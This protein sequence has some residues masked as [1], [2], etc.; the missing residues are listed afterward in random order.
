MALFAD[1]SALLSTAP[2]NVEVA[3]PRLRECRD[4]GLFQVVPALG[5]DSVARCLRCNAVMR[6]TRRD[7]L[8]R[9]LALNIAALSLFGVACLMSLMTVSTAGMQ[10]SANLFSGPEGL[11]Q[12]GIWELSVIV[13]FTTVA[14]PFLRFASMVYVLAGLRMQRPP[15]HL[16]QVFSWMEH[17]R[18]WSMIEVY[19]LGV[20]VAYVK[21]VGMVHIEIG[22]A[23]YAL[24][25]LMLTTVAA[26]AV[27]DRQAVWDEME[28]RGIPRCRQSTMPRSRSPDPEPA[29]SRCDT[30]GL[31]SM[32][33]P[34]AASHCPR[35]GSHLHARK[36][37]S[38]Q[39]TWALLIASVILYVPANVYPVL[40]VVQLGSGAPS[41]ILG[42]VEEL[43]G[44]R[45]VAAGG[46]GFLRQHHGAGAQA[47]RP[48]DHAGDHAS[49]LG[50][51]TAR[52]HGAVPDRQR[53]R[54]LVDDRHLH[55]ID[56]GRPRPVRL[57]GHD[58]T[59]LR[60][61]GVRRGRDPD[62][63]RCRSIRPAAHVGRCRAIAGESRMT[64]VTQP[65]AAVRSR[66]DRRRRM[67]LIWVIPLVTVLI[68]AWLVWDTY[69]KRGPTITITFDG[70]EGLQAGQSHVKHKDL[71]MGLVKSLVLTKDLQHV[72]VT[73]QMNREAE[74]LLTDRA[75]F[76]VVKPRFSAGNISG[77]STLLSGSYIA[78]L[79][80]AEGGEKQRHFTGLENPPVLQSNIA[81]R[82]FL[83]KANRIGSV[84]PG[85]P[86]FYRDLSVGE[87]LGWDLGDMAET[88]TIHAFVRAPFD[89][90]VH[91]DSRFWNASGV[92][93]KLGRRGR[94]VCN[95]N[96][97]RRC[98]LAGSPSRRP[99][100]PAT[101]PP[102]PRTRISRSMPT[103]T[104]PIR[105]GSA[106]ECRISPIS[107]APSAASARARR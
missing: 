72:L 48:D 88:V 56:P 69:S 24:G 95:S 106:A 34:H 85:S 8:G 39:R 37:A 27:L 94:A 77:L 47:G 36:P 80:A 21:L 12:H 2:A 29:R 64:D 60:R 57:G 105:P 99:P 90:Y 76:W 25:A 74:P 11:Q 97:C 31:V 92:S 98:C 103:R 41:T 17:L 89:Q 91:D 26:D 68:A 32:P 3:P 35:C 63:V 82:T 104:P 55:G 59:G 15:R 9:A 50:R 13:L 52:P 79:P 70:A 71:D 78:L 42:G 19:L 38:I 14:A 73:V 10:L 96:R 75:Q 18:P 61:R 100:S 22:V 84:S 87:V 81:G 102:A 5:P 43:L 45:H 30:C 7:P 6:R 28:R 1:P 58:R 23:L 54:P 46:A 83:L 4:C 62:D 65:T 93:V 107:R 40:T 33:V 51:P 67:S 49:R 101:L 86:I 44:G 66:V 20:F 53:D 16:R